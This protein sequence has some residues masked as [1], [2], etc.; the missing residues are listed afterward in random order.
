MAMFAKELEFTEQ[1]Y[2]GCILDQLM[3]LRIANNYKTTPHAL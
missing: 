2:N 3:A 1:C